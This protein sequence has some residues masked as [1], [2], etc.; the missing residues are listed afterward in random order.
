MPSLAYRPRPTLGGLTGP[1]NLTAS[2][3][4]TPSE[5]NLFH[6]R[7]PLSHFPR[8]LPPLPPPS[9][10]ITLLTPSP[11]L[12]PS[13]PPPLP[14][15]L[16]PSP[17]QPFPLPL[18]LTLPSPF[19]SHAM[20]TSPSLHP[21]LSLPSPSPSPSPSPPSPTMS[22]YIL[23]IYI[24]PCTISVSLLSIHVVLVWVCSS[25]ARPSSPTTCITT[26][27]C[28][29]GRET[30]R[31]LASTTTRRT[32]RV[33]QQPLCRLVFSSPPLSPFQLVFHN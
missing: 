2:L 32:S 5:P 18:P 28:T 26:A 12:S 22:L 23:Y 13:P 15:L 9:S 20:S 3:S 14:F 10:S 6:H 29:R 24:Q 25:V 11:T 21:P 19:H 17:S 7:L 27:T 1:R 33:D 31:G 4:P 30:P 16:S 8:S